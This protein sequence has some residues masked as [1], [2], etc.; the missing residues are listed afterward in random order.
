MV[1]VTCF[2]RGVDM[3]E[4]KIRLQSVEDA[5]NFVKVATHCDFDVD[6]YANSIVV[7]AKSIL[8][9]M[10]MDFRHV[11]TVRYN[12]ESK[13]FEAFLNNHMKDIEKIA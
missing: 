4:R 11:L 13:E 7:D 6:L 5:K 8:G 12:G 3:K 2:I 10:C 9:V 1:R